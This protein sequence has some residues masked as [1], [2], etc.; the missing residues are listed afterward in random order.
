VSGGVYY[1]LLAGPVADAETGQLCCSSWWTPGT[2]PPST[3]G[4]SAPPSTRSVSGEYD[5]QAQARVRV[6]ELAAAQIP[7]YVVRIRY[8]PGAPRYRVYGGAFETTA[9]AEVMRQ[10]LEEAEVEAEL[11]PETGEPIA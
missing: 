2:R 5:T 3:A 11:V 1:R 10:M 7:A 6:D 4:P 9:E 8:D